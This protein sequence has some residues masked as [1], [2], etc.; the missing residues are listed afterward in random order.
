VVQ[1]L[2]TLC[3]QI[4]YHCLNSSEKCLISKPR[5]GRSWSWS[6][7]SLIYNYLCNQCLSPPM[8]WIR[9]PL[10]RGVLDRKLCYRVCQWVVAGRWFSPG[11]PVSY[12]NTTDHHEI[13]EIL[14]IVALTT[15]NPQTHHWYHNTGYFQPPVVDLCLNKIWM[16]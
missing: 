9:T 12:T 11:T 10:R 16:H 6:Y 5:E 15:I 13:T 3:H 8:L 4:I 1:Y 2:A 7:V 14:L